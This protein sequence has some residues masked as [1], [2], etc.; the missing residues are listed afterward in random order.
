MYINQEVITCYK[1]IYAKIWLPKFCTNKKYVVPGPN[2]AILYFWLRIHCFYWLFIYIQIK[3]Y[4][5]YFNDTIIIL[6][7]KRPKMIWCCILVYAMLTA[8]GKEKVCQVYSQWIIVGL[9]KRNK[10]NKGRELKIRGKNGEKNKRLVWKNKKMVEKKES[11][12][13]SWK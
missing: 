4:R 8:K 10:D 5:F 11:K 2:R 3:G 9:L 12:N 1:D 6:S 13:R 7:F